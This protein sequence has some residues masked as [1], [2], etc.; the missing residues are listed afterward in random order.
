M[1][2]LLTALPLQAMAE[3]WQALAGQQ[4]ANALAFRTLGFPD[5]VIQDFAADGILRRDGTTGR[6]RVTATQY[7]A[8]WP[9]DFGWTCYSVEREARG[10]DIRFTG[11]GGSVTVGRYIDLQ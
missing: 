1:I 4:I 3:E 2:L 8:A 10:L 5:G 9:P 6:W 7:C 11:E